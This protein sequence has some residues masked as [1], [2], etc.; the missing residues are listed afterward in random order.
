MKRTFLSIDAADQYYLI[1]SELTVGAPHFVK[2]PVF[3]VLAHKEGV[4]MSVTVGDIINDETK[5]DEE[6]AIQADHILAGMERYIESGDHDGVNEIELLKVDD[7]YRL[8]I[9]TEDDTES[10]DEASLAGALAHIGI[11]PLQYAAMLI[12]EYLPSSFIAALSD[13]DILHWQADGEYTDLDWDVT[14]KSATD[15][16]A[17]LSFDLVVSFNRADKRIS[18]TSGFNQGHGFECF[19]T[20]YAKEKTSSRELMVA[21]VNRLN[22]E[23]EIK[24]HFYQMTIEH[25]EKWEILLN[26]LD[27][28]DKVLD[29]WI[30]NPEL[31][32]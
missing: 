8:I 15:T 18:L 7:Q 5:I 25:K 4:P 21:E 28:F 2:Y 20:I 23:A 24:P 32:K 17:R 29:E 11:Q 14:I 19:G 26:T 27:S 1:S 6:L 31:T 9:A 10:F 22:A 3:P 12:P 30:S 13:I 16:E